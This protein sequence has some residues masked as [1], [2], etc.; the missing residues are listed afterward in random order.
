MFESNRTTSILIKE[1]TVLPS[2]VS[3]ETEGFLH[4][5]RMVKSPDRSTLVRSIESADWS[6][7]YLAGEMTA[8]IFGRDRVSV[9]RRAVKSVLARYKVHKF[10]CLEVT[11]VVSRRFLGI[12]PFSRITI[13]SHHIQESLALVPAKVFVLRMPGALASETGL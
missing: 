10:N 4:G 5:W 7:F 9:L 2:G 12:V 3:I 6:F 1:G 13:H 8:T 11:R